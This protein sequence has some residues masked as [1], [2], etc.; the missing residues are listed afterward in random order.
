ML[1]VAMKTTIRTLYSKGYSKTMIGK[2]LDIDRK[3]VRKVST[4]AV[5]YGTIE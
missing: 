1:E 5:E 3:T 2:M 4:C